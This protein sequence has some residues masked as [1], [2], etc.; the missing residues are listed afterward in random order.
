MLTMFRS[1]R[2]VSSIFSP[3]TISN[4][5]YAKKMKNYDPLPLK[6]SNPLSTHIH[7]N[8]KASV[9]HTSSNSQDS[10]SVVV[11]INQS[12]SPVAFLTS[13]HNLK[14]ESVVQ[15]II[16]IDNLLFYHLFNYWNEFI[17]NNSTCAC[18]K[19][20]IQKFLKSCP[21]ALDKDIFNESVPN[22]FIWHGLSNFACWLLQCNTWNLKFD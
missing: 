2:S 11:D 13:L 5:T 10:Y 1:E 19:S 14:Y 8:H 12:S 18:S 9:C 7:V 15:G 21:E 6:S 4:R 22:W 16:L 3:Y 17:V 20:F